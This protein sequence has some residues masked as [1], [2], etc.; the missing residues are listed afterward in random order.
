MTVQSAGAWA[1]RSS[2]STSV[3]LKWSLRMVRPSSGSRS[4]GFFEADDEAEVGEEDFGELAAVVGI[5]LGVEGLIQKMKSGLSR[6][7][8]SSASSRC[9]R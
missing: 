8:S 7:F 6:A 1:G 3:I 4:P 9:Q 2:R 5:E